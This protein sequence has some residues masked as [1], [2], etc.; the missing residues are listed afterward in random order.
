M[1]NNKVKQTEEV[2]ISIEHIK[3]NCETIA[4]VLKLEKDFVSN[5]FGDK[6]LTIQARNKLL[7]RKLKEEKEFLK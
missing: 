7:K 1:K 5:E 3:E 6:E 4:D 2:N